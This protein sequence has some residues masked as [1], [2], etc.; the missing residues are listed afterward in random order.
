[1]VFYEG[2]LMIYETYRVTQSTTRIP[3]W[4]SGNRAVTVF[5]M[6]GKVMEYII[7]ERKNPY[8][9]TTPHPRQP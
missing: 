7:S 5:A 6:F 3:N 8:R 1:M 2:F 9:D 4:L